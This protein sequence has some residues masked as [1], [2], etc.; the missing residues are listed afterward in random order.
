MP[1]T[2]RE[3]FDEYIINFF[4]NEGIPIYSSRVNL[5]SHASGL[6]FDYYIPSL[7]LGIDYGAEHSHTFVDVIHGSVGNFRLQLIENEKTER[8]CYVNGITFLRLWYYENQ[9]SFLRRLSDAIISK[10]TPECSY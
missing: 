2:T 3:N 1:P 4:D 7:N 10:D 5:H 8:E 9:D 6:V